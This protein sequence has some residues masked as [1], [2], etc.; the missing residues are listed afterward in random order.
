MQDRELFAFPHMLYWRGTAFSQCLTESQ[1]KFQSCL[2]LVMAF[3]PHLDITSSCVCCI[4]LASVAQTAA[5]WSQGAKES[6]SL[7]TDYRAEVP[8]GSLHRQSPCNRKSRHLHWPQVAQEAVWGCWCL[9]QDSF[10]FVQKWIINFGKIVQGYCKRD[11]SLFLSEK[12]HVFPSAPP[13]SSGFIA[14]NR[15]KTQECHSPNSLLFFATSLGQPLWDFPMA[16]GHPNNIAN[17][18]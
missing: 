4:S 18:K 3:H 16:G 17:S 5:S 9:S 2:P 6:I 7:N 11:S 14:V 12:S 1:L 10:D 15:G 13:D 8:G